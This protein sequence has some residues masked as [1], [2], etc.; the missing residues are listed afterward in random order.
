MLCPKCGE[1]IFNGI[2]H[3]CLPLFKVRFAKEVGFNGEWER[4]WREVRA[5]NPEE[6]GEKYGRLID[7]EANKDNAKME[8]TFNMSNPEQGSYIKLEVL[9]ADGKITKC[10]LGAGLT[11]YYVCEESKRGRPSLTNN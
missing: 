9:S 2:E 6:A 4:T 7:A 8:F 3:R 5:R 11:T 1:K 10:K